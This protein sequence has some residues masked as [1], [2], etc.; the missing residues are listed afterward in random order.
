MNGKLGL[1]PGDRSGEEEVLKVMYFKQ[2]LINTFFP[3]K[4]KKLG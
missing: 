1:H 2:E 4:K 3:K